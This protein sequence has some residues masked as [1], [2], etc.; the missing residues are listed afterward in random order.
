MDLIDKWL[1]GALGIVL[2]ILGVTFFF[3]IKPAVSIAGNVA[4]PT[5]SAFVVYS[6]GEVADATLHL[7]TYQD[8]SCWR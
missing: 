5:K 2:V 3:L 7:E 4:I 6:D 8:H 1:A